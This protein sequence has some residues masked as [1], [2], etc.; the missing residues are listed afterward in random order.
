[1]TWFSEYSASPRRRLASSAIRCPSVDRFAGF[2]VPSRVSGQRLSLRGA[3]LPSAGS[4]RA[5]FP[6]LIGYYEGATTSRVRV[7]GPLWIRFQAPRAP[8]SSCSPRRSRSGG[9]PLPGLGTLVSRSAPLRRSARGHARDLSGF[10]AFPP[11][12]LPGSQTPA[13]PAGP[14]PLR[15][16]RCCPRDHHAEGSSEHIISRLTPGFGIRCLRFT[17]GVAVTHARL[18]SGWRAAAFAGR[19]SNPLERV[20]RFQVIPF[21]FPGLLLTLGGSTPT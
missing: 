9:G 14:R 1:M 3:S 11:I 8:P 7:P 21:S 18:A 16:C 12:P 2:R 10:L 19:E 5:R 6:V 13:G 17:S 20:E 15:P 4:R